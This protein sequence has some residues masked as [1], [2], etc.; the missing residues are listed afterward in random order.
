VCEAI[1]ILLESKVLRVCETGVNDRIHEVIDI[2]PF[3]SFGSVSFP[4]RTHSELDIQFSSEVNSFHAP[5]WQVFLNYGHILL[6]NMCRHLPENLTVPQLVK[7]YS[8]FNKT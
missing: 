1:L 4:S 8:A 6:T 7:K 3:D 5:F 2:L